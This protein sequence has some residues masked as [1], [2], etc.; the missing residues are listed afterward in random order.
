MKFWSA[1]LACGTVFAAVACM[2][3]ETPPPAASMTPAQWLAK[4]QTAWDATN[5][6]SATIT[7]HEALN[8]KTQDRVYATVF[9]KPTSIRVDI[10]AGDGKGSVAVYQGGDN[11]RGHQGGWLS[12][13][14]LN[15]NIHAR[16]ATTLRGTTIVQSSFAYMLDHVKTMKYK[17]TDVTVNG[18]LAT[19]TA[20]PEDPAQDDGYA[21]TVLTLGANGLP[22][23]LDLY[24][25]SNEVVKI[26][27][28]T[29]VKVNV[30]VPASTWQV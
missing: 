5:T 22:V 6:Y 23:E 4:F 13:I 8:G 27:K 17:S 28:Y 10:T 16:L 20:V 24:D 19:M 29:D 14:K 12:M 26:N 15:L 1:A 7:A 30:D 11:V 9:Q 18:D 21:K 3:A 2:G 25:A